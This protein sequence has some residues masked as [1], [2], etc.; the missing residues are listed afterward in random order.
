MKKNWNKPQINN[1]SISLTEEIMSRGAVARNQYGTF[2]WNCKCCLAS[3]SGYED[4]DKAA[5]DLEN[6]FKATH[7]NGCS[8]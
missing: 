7:P 5:E 4:E 1:L 2:D 3:G 6:H 8:A